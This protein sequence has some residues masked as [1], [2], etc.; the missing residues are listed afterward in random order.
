MAWVG[1]L[2]PFSLPGFASSR[3]HVVAQ[4]ESEEEF[5]V[6]SMVDLTLVSRVEA[7]R[8]PGLGE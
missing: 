6:P 8:G 4:L 5:W 3:C 7:R 2:L 1:L